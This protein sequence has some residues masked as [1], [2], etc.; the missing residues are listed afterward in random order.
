MAL[1]PNK[2]LREPKGWTRADHIKLVAS[3][4]DIGRT[5]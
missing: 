3:V 4:G 5:G 2:K 1:M